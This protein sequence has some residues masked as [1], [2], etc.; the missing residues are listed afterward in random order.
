MSVKQKRQGMRNDRG[1]F[2]RVPGSGVWWVR[3]ADERGKIH[4][5]K[6]GPKGLA[7][8]V[9]EKRK[10]EVREGRF[11]PKAVRHIE[12]TVSE[13]IDGYLLRK[14]GILRHFRHYKRLGRYWK[15]A[16]GSRSLGSIEPAEIEGYAAGRR[17]T[18]SPATVN[19]ELAFLKRIYNDA[20]QNGK[21]SA[22]PVRRV[23]L[24][25]ENNARVRFLTEEEENKLRVEMT[26]ENWWFVVLALNTGLRQA[27]QFNLRW[28]HVNFD[29]GIITI[30]R[31]KNG[32]V[33]HVPMNDTV[34]VVLSELPS[35]M[36]SDWVFPT[37]RGNPT[38]ADTWVLRKFKP[39]L[40]RAG[41]ADFHWHD[42]RHTFASR[43]VMRHVPLTTVKELMG[44]KTIAMT[45]RYSHLAPEHLM[46]AVQ[47]LS[48]TTTSTEDRDK[49]KVARNRGS[50]PS[51]RRSAKPPCIGSN[52]IAASTR[53]ISTGRWRARNGGG[54]QCQF[55]GAPD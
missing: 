4:R 7:R 1:I 22:N 31:S 35:R 9:Y 21:V 10:T 44:H 2:E 51:H 27:E 30:P 8:K 47:S 24:F 6:V 48:D 33:R 36:R 25:K 18:V 34:R 46:Q 55:D 45:L 28:E 16:Y 12:Q 26:A 20:I 32:E 37:R 53:R 43:L 49:P 54:S 29:T 42:L 39:A 15:D 14:E 50:F 13:A 5:E 41:I 17:K 40:G 11:F 52:P 19:R 38:Q 3:Y 23:K